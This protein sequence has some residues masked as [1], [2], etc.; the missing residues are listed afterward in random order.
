MAFAASN[1]AQRVDRAV[2]SGFQAQLNKEA[3]GDQSKYPGLR[4]TVTGMTCTQVKT[5]DNYNCLAHYMLVYKTTVVKYN[6][7]I[8]AQVAGTTIS[9]QAHGGIPVG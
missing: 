5:S 8:T 7:K 3:R 6:D 2:T 4:F 1:A 9:W